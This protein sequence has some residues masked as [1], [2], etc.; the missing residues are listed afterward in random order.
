MSFLVT[1][2]KWRPQKFEEVVGQDGVSR[3]LQNAIKAGR[4]AHSYI[5]AGP[6]GIGKT[7][8]ARLLAKA[9][10]CSKGP[11]P[12]PCGQCVPC[13][14]I[15]DGRCMDVLE[16]DGAS[17]RGVGEI[18]NLRDNIHFNPASCRKKIYI[19]D[20]VH[21]LTIEAFNA[22][23]KTL[24]EPP[25]HAL[26]IFATTEIN[27]VPATILSRC[28][29]FDFR[30]L[31]T[32]E[33]SGH[34]RHIADQE[35]L[36]ATDEAIGLIARRADG[37]MRDAQSLLDQMATFSPEGITA[38][39]VRTAL[40][41]VPEELY[42][43]VSDLVKDNR[44]QDVFTIVE[45][46]D[47]RGLSP[48]ELL[49][50]LCDHFLN[51]MKAAEPSG[52]EYIE[53]PDEVRNQYRQEAPKFKQNDLLRILAILQEAFSE[54]RRH[55]QPRLKL[56]LTLLR[57]ASLER[58]ASIEELIDS[59]QGNKPPQ[60]P[61]GGDEP[62][63]TTP[64]KSR[65]STPPEPPP[66][67]VSTRIKEPPTTETLPLDMAVI[68][69]RWSSVVERICAGNVPL[70]SQLKLGMP[71][72]L[73]DDILTVGFGLDFHDMQ[74]ERL[75]KVAASGNLDDG[76]KQVF[77]SPLRIRFERLSKAEM[78]EVAKSVEDED[79]LETELIRCLGAKRI[80]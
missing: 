61:G 35:G 40:G 34:L 72:K 4:I 57:L 31:A 53:A 27:R 78:E 69:S 46:F 20:E 10:N 54:I 9:I 7:T 21:M 30:R 49:R 77:A 17:N 45:D 59:L 23:L 37:A 62:K 48:G 55:P 64:D 28:Q 71:R 42:F 74:I 67:P 79:P 73:E 56:E 50:G 65:S 76:I 16:I 32:A 19:I 44:T 36:K 1:A 15:P 24:E 29:R 6:R 52:V 80:A 39:E 41:I 5:F 43:K 13:K 25:A 11:T 47:T 68:K 63:V 70:V 66:E 18:R 75:Q 58:T 12:D 2:R 8:T 33:I 26:F 3:T 51:L 22:L 14:E 38:E 60:P